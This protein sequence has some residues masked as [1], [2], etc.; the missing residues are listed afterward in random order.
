MQTMQRCKL[1]LCFL[2]KG[3]RGHFFSR[4]PEHGVESVH[5][6]PNYS[7][8]TSGRDECWP[9]CTESSLVW[10]CSYTNAARMAKRC[11][12]FCGQ[13]W[14]TFCGKCS[15]KEHSPWHLVK[16]ASKVTL[17]MP[18]VKTQIKHYQGRGERHG[19][20]SLWFTLD[21]R[22]YHFLNKMFCMLHLL[23]TV[24]FYFTATTLTRHLSTSEGITGALTSST[25]QCICAPTPMRTV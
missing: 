23:E 25:P 10:I 9:A 4:I 14:A 5:Y 6:L 21:T 12:S 15:W 24:T 13:R 2:N 18:L 17:L 7:P 8:F 16:E 1:F 19:E 3:K 20:R 11:F 22:K